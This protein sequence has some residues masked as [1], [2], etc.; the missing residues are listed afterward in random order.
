MS[1]KHTEIKEKIIKKMKRWYGSG[2]TEYPQSGHR[3]DNFSVTLSGISLYIE[4]IWSDTKSNF[5]RDLL[6]I[7]RAESEIKIAVVNPKIL[8]KN[9]LVREYEKEVASERRRGVKIW[10]TMINGDRILND[11]SYLDVEFKQILDSLLSEFQE[12]FDTYDYNKRILEIRIVNESKYKLRSLP[13]MEIIIT[14]KDQPNKWFISDEKNRFF[15]SIAPNVNYNKIFSSTEHFEAECYDDAI[16]MTYIDGSFHWIFTIIHNND[17]NTI[18]YNSIMKQ[19]LERLIYSVQIMKQYNINNNY[20]INIYMKNI[21]SHNI[22]YERH[23]RDIQYRFKSIKNE[24]EI[25]HEFNPSH[26]WPEIKNTFMSIY[27]DILTNSGNL[28]PKD[29]YITSNLKSM[30]PTITYIRTKFNAS[31]PDFNVDNI[32]FNEFEF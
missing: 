19:I 23:Y 9:E 29:T 26:K 4:I 1:V 5:Q 24:V 15:I 31:N 28:Y 22:V 2:I 11:E 3:L 30:I 12:P 32:N 20:L 16:F 14:S 8:M 13:T 21:F 27:R 18:R 17:E 7:S 6:M 25:S 10:G